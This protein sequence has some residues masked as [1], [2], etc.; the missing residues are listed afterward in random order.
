[1][2]LEALVSWTLVGSNTILPLLLSH[3]WTL[4][5]QV[6]EESIYHADENPGLLCVVIV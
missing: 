1:M 6:V 4:D 2:Y 5:I 3:Q